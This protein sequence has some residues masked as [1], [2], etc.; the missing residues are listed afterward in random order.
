MLAGG[1]IPI[2]K[3]LLVEDDEDDYEIT[4]HLLSKSKHTKFQV[5]RVATYQEGK[6]RILDKAFDVCLI[7]YRLGEKSGLDLLIETSD[8]LA[9]API[10]L[11]TGQGDENVDREAA[12]A[13]A[14]DY[15]VKGKIDTEILERS[16]RY[17]LEQAIILKKLVNS[18]KMSALGEMSASIAHEIN[19]PLTI[20]HGHASNL[21]AQIDRPTLEREKMKKYL[22]LI[23]TTS[24]RI[25]KTVRSLRSFSRDE[26]QDLPERWSL[27]NILEDTVELCLD[28]FQRAH[29]TLTVPSVNETQIIFCRPTEII[30]ALLNLL[31]N[32]FDAVEGLKEKW[33]RVDVTEL[34]RFGVIAITDSGKGI[35]EA[36]CDKILQP[37]FTTKEAGK[38]T[39]LGLTIVKKIVEDHHGHLEIDRT[40][41]NTR[42]IL[43]LPTGSEGQGRLREGEKKLEAKPKAPQLGRDLKIFICDDDLKIVELLTEAFANQGY[44]VT[45]CHDGATA[46]RKINQEEFDVIV[47]DIMMPFMNGIRVSEK[48]QSGKFNRSTPVFIMSGNIDKE[49]L[50]KL[51]RNGISRVLTKPFELSE[52]LHRVNAVVE[53]KIA[54]RQPG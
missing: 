40:S 36:L 42:F 49:V 3:V 35:P 10:I 1:V 16:I 38:G 53:K 43:K 54:D 34:D 13:G 4:R 11:L 30:Q 21:I 6:D 19:G 32:A 15:L 39:G 46:L 9:H 7:D 18:S 25:A 52:I 17:A 41:P 20:I 26:G 27:R 23:C 45:S 14:S 50:G 33:V 47:L 48:I 37:F 5:S 28:H 22:D 24:L 2:V 12:R 31:T 51:I 44:K 29:I 8:K